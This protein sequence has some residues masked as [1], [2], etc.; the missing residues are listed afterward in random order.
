M[1]TFKGENRVKIDQV[2]GVE[3]EDFLRR[4]QAGS[5]VSVPAYSDSRQSLRSY[6]VL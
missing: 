1:T 6:A 2:A 4:L 3:I 5:P